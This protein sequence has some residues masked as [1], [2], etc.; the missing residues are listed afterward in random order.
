MKLIVCSLASV[1]DVIAA[2][3]PS[4]LVT[5]LSPGSMIETP[6]GLV[7]GAA[8]HLKVEV[9]D[10]DGEVE[11]LKA[12]D[13]ATVDRILAFGETWDETHPMLVHCFAGISRS[14]A[15]AFILA[16]ERSAPGDEARIARALRAASPAAHPNRLLV[17]LADARLGREGRMIAAIEAIGPGAFAAEN[18]PFDLPARRAP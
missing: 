3:A 4:H 18:A 13:A 5:L 1:D 10:I 17:S 12:P 16:C 11:G 14:T 7:G 9:N 6:A 15:T 8:R 2:R